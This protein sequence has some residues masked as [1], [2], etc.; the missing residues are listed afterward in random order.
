[1]RNCIKSIVI[2]AWVSYTLI[3]H[4]KKGADER[5][6]LKAFRENKLKI[7]TQ[8]GICDAHWRKD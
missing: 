5:M 8:S 4:R 1:M 2:I 3:H 7:K 6:D